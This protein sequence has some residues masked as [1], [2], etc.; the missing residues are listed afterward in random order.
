P[1]TVATSMPLNTVVALLRR[2]WGP[3]PGATHIRPTPK[4][5]DNPGMINARNRRESPNQYI[6]KKI[7]IT[8][9]TRS[10]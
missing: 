2:G 4:I 5:K 6:I 7:T 9:K 3:A 1:T 10:V 8:T